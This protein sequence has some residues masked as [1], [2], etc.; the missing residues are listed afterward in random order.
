MNKK[1]INKEVIIKSITKMVEDKALIRSY[2][3]GNTPIK[4]LTERGIK[5]VA[6]I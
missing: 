6:P 2:L 3:K 4:K 1:T 5:F